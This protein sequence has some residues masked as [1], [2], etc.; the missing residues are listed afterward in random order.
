MV[1]TFTSKLS[2]TRAGDRSRIWLEGKRLTGAGFLPG[3]YYVK[4]F[5]DDGLV[6][7]LSTLPVAELHEKYG[8]DLVGKISGKGEKPIID[9][10]G[11][12]VINAFGKGTHVN[13][14]Y[15]KGRI[16]ITG[17]SQ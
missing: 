17:A 7:K 1:D 15:R 8:R 2:T 5:S 16:T 12:S 14:E 4:S 10:V 3:M 13:V 11:V 6:L 9:I